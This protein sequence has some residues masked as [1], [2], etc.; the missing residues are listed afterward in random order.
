MYISHFVLKHC[1]SK[2]YIAIFPIVSNLSKA[3]VFYYG[4]E[5]PYFQ[6]PVPNLSQKL[7]LYQGITKRPIFLSKNS[8][9]P[10]LILRRMLVLIQ[11]GSLRS[12]KTTTRPF[13]PLHPSFDKSNR[14]FSKPE[15]FLKKP[16]KIP[17]RQLGMRLS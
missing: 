12:P 6:N 4:T 11:I 16:L 7:G 17:V 8:P 13:N 5:H 15:I 14:Y 2:L 9:K 3:F 1:K 10:P